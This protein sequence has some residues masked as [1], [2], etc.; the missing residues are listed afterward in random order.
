MV[1]YR[2]LCLG[3]LV[4]FIWAAN[5]AITKYVTLEVPPF[6]G[7]VLRLSLACIF[8]GAF[9]R[10]LPKDKFILMFQISVFLGV[11]HWGSLIWSVD[12]LDISTVNIVM[13]TQIIFSACLG[14]L[15]FKEKIGWRTVFGMLCGIAGIIVLVGLPQEQPSLTGIAALLFSIFMVAL[16]FTR[17]KVLSDISPLNYIAHLHLLGIVPVLFIA[18]I[19]E[20]PTEIPWHNV[21]YFILIPCLLFQVFVASASHTV[22]Q[23]LISRNQLSILPNLTLLLPVFGVALGIIL[24]DE[25]LHSGIIFGGLLTMTGVGIIMLRKQKKKTYPPVS[26]A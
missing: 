20:N 23:R 11:L 7:L 5:S 15:L 25:T 12:K 9:F 4:I 17:Q 3:V 24:F 18:F 1:S 14:W 10:P 13:Q 26:N 22:W 19:M 21:N 2:D 16:S 6:T 8:F